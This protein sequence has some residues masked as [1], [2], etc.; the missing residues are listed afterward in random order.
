[1]DK[2]K[3]TIKD[4]LQSFSWYADHRESRAR[5]EYEEALGSLPV[6]TANDIR[7]IEQATTAIL[8]FS[9]IGSRPT[10]STGFAI[11]VDG[12][13]YLTTNW[14]VTNQSDGTSKGFT[15]NGAH[16]FLLAKGKE[17]AVAQ[18]MVANPFGTYCGSKEPLPFKDVSLLQIL[19]KADAAALLQQLQSSPSTQERIRLTLKKNRFDTP[20]SGE[21][22]SQ[23]LAP[24]QLKPIVLNETDEPLFKGNVATYKPP[25]T[26]Y[27]ISF[28]DRTPMLTLGNLSGKR[29]SIH[30]FS[31]E[32]DNSN[33]QFAANSGSP[34]AIYLPDKFAVVGILTGFYREE[35]RM[36][37]SLVENALE[38]I[39][40]LNTG[41]A[42]KV[43]RFADLC[44]NGAL[45]DTWIDYQTPNSGQLPT[46]PKA[47]PT[48]RR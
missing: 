4:W 16:Y 34:A 17:L 9:T 43:E 1:M 18:Q 13:D 31:S 42:R 2:I 21:A 7:K 15:L 45:T 40:A 14:H 30:E 28:R 22:L 37:A 36:D 5:K 8:G 19:P 44:V 46:V 38:G 26:V 12:R 29:R 24:F 11:R 27:T 25:G 41:R 39:K 47:T 20:L 10:E 48:I 6:P 35:Q 23:A 3:N 33:R 32:Y